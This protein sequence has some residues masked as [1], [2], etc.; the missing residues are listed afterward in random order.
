VKE[1]S[2]NFHES[3]YGTRQH[4]QIEKKLTKISL[5]RMRNFTTNH[6]QTNVV[7]Q[8]IWIMYRTFK[9][10]GRDPYFLGI[11]IIEAALLGIFLGTLFSNTKMDHLII[12]NYSGIIFFVLSDISFDMV[13]GTLEKFPHDFPIMLRDR[14]CGLYSPFIYYF[15]Q[16]LAG[17]MTGIMLVLIRVVILFWMVDFK[18]GEGT[19][20]FIVFLQFLTIYEIIMQAAL[21]YGFMICCIAGNFSRGLALANPMMLIP[22]MFAG[23]FVSKA[24]IPLFI[25][26]I[27]YLS[28]F[29]YGFEAL[30]AIIWTKVGTIP[31]VCG[32]LSLTSDQVLS[33]FDYKDE[34]AYDVIMIFVLIITYHVVAVI[35]LGIRTMR[36]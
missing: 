24:S 32:N 12:R 36:K 25:R 26:W 30:S 17:L 34:V 1:I 11:K 15:T 21:A 7:N 20:K 28:F 6:Y 27:S 4:S 9:R 8:F 22:M 18:V 13:Y 29:F 10:M 14:S 16:V 3:V 33:G 5:S 31:S 19:E 35:S 23:F 2:D